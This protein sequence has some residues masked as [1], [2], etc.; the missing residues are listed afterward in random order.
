MGGKGSLPLLWRGVRATR[1]KITSGITNSLNLCA[2][3]TVDIWFTNVSAFRI[4][5]WRPAGWTHVN[6]N[7]AGG[8]KTHVEEMRIE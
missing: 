7:V 6:Q 1:V 8:R 2:A 4:T 5:T 3:L